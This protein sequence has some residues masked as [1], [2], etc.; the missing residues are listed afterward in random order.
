MTEWC[1]PNKPLPKSVRDA[2][3]K[4]AAEAKLNIFQQAL[5]LFPPEKWVD[6]SP[7]EIGPIIIAQAL[8]RLG[9]KLIEAASIAA[10]K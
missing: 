4:A 3:A 9:E 10:R 5:A 8:D 6:C 1:N 2:E 7:T